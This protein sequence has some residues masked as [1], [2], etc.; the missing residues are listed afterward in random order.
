MRR[1]WARPFEGFIVGL[2]MVVGFSQAFLSLGYPPEMTAVLPAW[3]LRFYG[4]YVLVAAVVW[5]VGIV[6][7]RLLVERAALTGLA[8]ALLVIAL[9]EVWVV[10]SADLPSVR[11]VDLMETVIWQVGL[12]VAAICRATF[13]SSVVKVARL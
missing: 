13:I 3:P 11:P 10:A 5:L 7:D 9:A 2:L 8:A 6:R 12:G 4:L 1:L